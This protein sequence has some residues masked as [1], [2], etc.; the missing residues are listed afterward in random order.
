MILRQFDSDQAF[1]RFGLILVLLFALFLRVDAANAQQKYA[2]TDGR[3]PAGI[4]VVHLKI[5]GEPVQSLAFFWRDRSSQYGSDKAGLLALGPQLLLTGGSGLID[6]GALE[7]DLKDLGVLIAIRRTPALSIG[8]IAGMPANL[9]EAAR[10]LSSILENPR[11]PAKQL[12]RLKRAAGASA[13]AAGEKAESIAGN[14]L[15][16][17]LIG[18][19]PH[20]SLL[21]LQPLEVISSVTARD[22]ASWH[23]TALAR[24]NLTVVAAGPFE[25]AKA[26]TLVDQA[27]STLPAD[28]AVHAPIPLEVR[29]TP[30]TVVL[31]RPVE[32]SVILIGA[33]TKWNDAE[34][35]IARALAFNV[36]GG[37]PSSRLW[38]AVREKL[39]AAYGAQAQVGL[40]GNGQYRFAMQASVANDK[41]GAALEAMRNEYARFLRDGVSDVEIEP[42]K[43]RFLS[44]QSEAMRKSATAASA[45]RG[46]LI[47]GMTIDAPNTYPQRLASV[48]AATIND[49][50]RKNLTPG[51]TTIIVT[52]SAAGIAADCVIR[53]MD[54]VD[55]CR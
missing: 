20:Y 18:D 16:R 24:S 39:G 44:G 15:T 32:Q 2:I 48:S 37:G 52:P 35:G 12:E 9:E 51:V 29:E 30:R 38:L 34:E 43:R 6:G 27:F 25:R 22:V 31:E 3:S 36:L 4:R 19:Q 42:I 41:V 11:L 54:E 1:H 49:L 23:R 33:P 47:L 53:A 7:E 17:M 46:A 10:L 14:L 50:I 13:K 21:T 28:A 8:E 26:E 5:E 55:R 40:L 45:I